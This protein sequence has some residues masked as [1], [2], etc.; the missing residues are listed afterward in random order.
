MTEEELIEQV[1]GADR[2]A[3]APASCATTPRGT[4]STHR[5]GSAR[6]SSRSRIAGSRRRSIPRACRRPRARCCAAFVRDTRDRMRIDKVYTRGGDTGETSLI[7]GERVSKAIARIE[8]YGTIDELNA[9][10]A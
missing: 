2:P 7:G 3:S 9:R 8:C 5:R 1:A 4:I 10:S 6:T